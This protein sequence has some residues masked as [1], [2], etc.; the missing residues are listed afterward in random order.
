M[1]RGHQQDERHAEGGQDEDTENN[2]GK[3][4]RD[5]VRDTGIR[6][7]YGIQDVA[8]WGGQRRMDENR[9]QK[10]ALE[11]NPSGAR[12]PGGPPKRWGDS[13]QST[14]KKETQRQRQN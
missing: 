14:S 4:R 13:W 8:R 12:P 10:I 11:G 5:G 6:E 7:Q 2:S 1:A 9:L 3:T